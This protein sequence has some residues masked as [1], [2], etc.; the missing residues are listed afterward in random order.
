MKELAYRDESQL[1]T[2]D[3]LMTYAEKKYK[4]QITLNQWNTPTPEQLQITAIRTEM[5]ELKN[6]KLD[7]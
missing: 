5:Q 3:E 2:T 7:S 4:T 6:E 1:F